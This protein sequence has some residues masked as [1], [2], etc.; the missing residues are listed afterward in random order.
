M[1]QQIKNTIMEIIS[2]GESQSIEFKESL[3]LLDEIGIAVS[4][5]SNS[6]GGKIII[7]I[8]G[9]RN[10]YSASRSSRHSQNTSIIGVSDGKNTIEELSNYLKRNIDPCIYPI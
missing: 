2:K 7:G 3:K 1:K 8:S 9:S 6:K 5:F 4:G 10:S